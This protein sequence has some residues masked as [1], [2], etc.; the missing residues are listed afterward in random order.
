M[1]HFGPCHSSSHM[2]GRVSSIRT[3]GECLH[4]EIKM[5]MVFANFSW[6][7]L[8]A[9]SNWGGNIID[10]RSLLPATTPN[11]TTKS[12]R[13]DLCAYAQR[14]YFVIWSEAQTIMAHASLELQEVDYHRFCCPCTSLHAMI[15]ASLPEYCYHAPFPSS[16]PS[17]V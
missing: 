10:L 5:R 17:A 2:S 11:R 6:W 4:H 7:S 16:L 13:L 12:F 8:S 15:A 1:A 3:S 9:R 14:F